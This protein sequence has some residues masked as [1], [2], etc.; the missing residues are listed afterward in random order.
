MEHHVNENTLSAF[1]A[2]LRG[3]GRSRGTIEKY[4]RDVRELVHWLDGRE[5]TK[6]TVALW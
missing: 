2:W 6:E 3:E 4:L 5:L 1:E